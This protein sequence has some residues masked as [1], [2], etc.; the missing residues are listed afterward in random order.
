MAVDH[1]KSYFNLPL[2]IFQSFHFVRELC[3]PS[4]ATQ[5]R[6]PRGMQIAPDAA[7]LLQSALWGGKRECDAL[8]IHHRLSK[9]CA[10]QQI[11]PIMHIGERMR[12][13]PPAKLRVNL[14]QLHGRIGPKAGEHQI[15]VNRQHA[16]PSL[17][18]GRRIGLS[19]QRHI[20]PHHLHRA[21]FHRAQHALGLPLQL[22]DQAPHHTLI[23]YQ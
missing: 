13:R 2:R 15:A 9:A 14:A 17:H 19:V 6:K 12:R 16:M 23:C 22:V 11:A 7:K 18:R 3:F 4:L 20:R 1:F 10:N 5:P 8:H 21:I